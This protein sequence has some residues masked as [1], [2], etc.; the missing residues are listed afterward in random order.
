MPSCR[1]NFDTETGFYVVTLEA[2]WYGYPK[3]G[4]EGNMI[5]QTPTV[6]PT[7]KK[8][9]FLNIYASDLPC[10]NSSKSNDSNDSNDSNEYRNRNRMFENISTF[11]LFFI[12]FLIVILAVQKF[13]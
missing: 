5:V 6:Y 9:G 3:V 1:P 12:M 2:F 7:P 13:T 10:V 8:E 11:F 4:K